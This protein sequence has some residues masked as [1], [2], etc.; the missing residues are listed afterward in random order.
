MNSGWMFAL[1]KVVGI[2]KTALSRSYIFF[3]FRRFLVINKR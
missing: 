2:L 1:K 3:V